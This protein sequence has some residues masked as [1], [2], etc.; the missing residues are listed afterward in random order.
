MV[1]AKQMMANLETKLGTWAKEKEKW[2]D[3]VAH[4]T[5]V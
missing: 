1:K 2:E 4:I 3:I 5:E